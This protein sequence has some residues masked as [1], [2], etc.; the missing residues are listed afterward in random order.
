MNIEL[1]TELPG[2]KSREL[3]AQRQAAVARGP[4]HVTPIFMARGSGARIEDVDGNRLLDFAGGLAV[5]NVGHCAPSVVAAVREQAE[6]SLHACFQVTPYE[7]YVR[8]CERLNALAP[9]EFTKKSFLANSGAEAVEN[10]VKIARA[11]T[12]R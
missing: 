2:P 10:A 11:Y 8:L 12:G 4:F 1:K 9:G 6:K 5:L 7:G 3:M